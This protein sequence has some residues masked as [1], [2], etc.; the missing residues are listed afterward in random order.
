[1]VVVRR[2]E[3]RNAL[4]EFLFAICADDLKPKLPLHQLTP[5]FLAATIASWDIVEF[6]DQ[7]KRSSSVRPPVSRTATCIFI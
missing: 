3:D 1:M 4:A 6:F 7:G 5:E 2:C